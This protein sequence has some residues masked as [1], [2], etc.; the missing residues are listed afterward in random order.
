MN[1]TGQIGVVIIGRNEGDRLRHCLQSVIANDR[2]VVYVDS[3]STDGSPDLATRMGADVVSLDMTIQFTAARARNAGVSRLRETCPHLIV[4]QFVDGDCEVNQSWIDTAVVHLNNHPNL[5]A[6]CGRRRE[7]FPRQ[8]VYNRLCDLEWDT[9][10]GRAEA[11]GGDA[12]FRADALT[13]V[14]GFRDSM[15][16]GE[17][18]ELCLRLRQAG[19]AIERIDHEMTLH[20]A[21]MTRFGQWWKRAVRAGHAYAEGAFLSRHD[22]RGLWRRESR[23]TWV[24]SLVPLLLVAMSWYWLGWWS[25]GWL[26][27]YP[28][29]WVRIWWQA[30]KRM[31]LGD[32]ALYATFCVIAKFAH[33]QGM[34]RFHSTRFLGRRSQLIE[35]KSANPPMVGQPS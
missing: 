9:P 11:C 19:G 16:A 15:I 3:G 5:V 8:S 4:V 12:M 34:L 31:K 29:L 24:W 18:P 10:V 22:Q 13:R 21:A 28:L 6:V 7:R 26:L 14:G 20:D 2:P 30:R 1:S 17:E 32:A 33:L 23:S 27:L 35:Y 25:L